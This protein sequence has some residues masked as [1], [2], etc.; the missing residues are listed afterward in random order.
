MKTFYLPSDASLKI[1]LSILRTKAKVTFN[2]QAFLSKNF[3]TL[4]T[5]RGLTYGS[6][7]SPNI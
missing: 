2:K 3:N 5:C 7:L 6:D 1:R 4:I